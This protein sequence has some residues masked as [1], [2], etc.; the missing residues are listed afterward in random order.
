MFIMMKKSTKRILAGIGVV[1]VLALIIWGIKFQFSIPVITG[2]T[3][4]KY[5]PAQTVQKEPLIGVIG[6]NDL[7]GKY[8]A[9][10]NTNF[11]KALE[12][13]NIYKEMELLQETKEEK[14]ELDIDQQ[15]HR[16]TFETVMELIGKNT[17]AGV[18]RKDDL[19][20]DYII[21]TSFQDITGIREKLFDRLSDDE[22][23]VEVYRTRGIQQ[24]S[25]YGF[26]TIFEGNI[27]AASTLDL[28]KQSMDLKAGEA[29]IGNFNT[30]FDWVEDKMDRRADGFVFIND[31]N[32]LRYLESIY[33]KETGQEVLRN[34]L[35]TNT[36]KEYNFDKGLEI[37][38]Y[39]YRK[40]KNEPKK[41][42]ESN[43]IDLIPENPMFAGS[44][45]DFSI[46]R[47]LEDFKDMDLPGLSENVDLEMFDEY[48]GSELGYALL[49]PSEESF[50]Q[51]L[52]AGILLIESNKNSSLNHISD[53]LEDSLDIEL[54]KF[55]F[56]GI[57]YQRGG[58]PIFMGQELS[59]CVG[60]LEYKGKSIIAVTSSK[61][62][63]EKIIKLK[64]G[65][66]NSLKDSASWQEVA[67]YL[68][69][70]YYS[71]KYADINS[72]VEKIGGIAAR[73]ILRDPDLANFLDSEPLT[74][75]SPSGSIT[76]IDEKFITVHSYF[77]IKDLDVESWEEIF[78][79]AE[80][81][82][83]N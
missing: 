13:S 7:S 69:D 38:S 39:S 1:V 65:E 68:P 52:P 23:V 20:P 12:Q 24:F 46:E 78:D 64:R 15:D 2:E 4:L 54:E 9:L 26:Y 47:K 51:M 56:E 34:F 30:K 29:K 3:L 72:F 73:L 17:V 18:Y 40:E 59:I 83:N 28:V 76:N 82:V 63:L 60:A 70:R 25:E 14:Q 8:G 44:I 81:F 10:K 71:F 19:K 41:S 53:L 79:S 5:V 55:S 75:L 35:G 66:N 77:P 6:V 36:Y 37:K 50:A 32:G 67:G 80:S 16:I 62:S 74:W 58:I 22:D 48:I 43:T 33:P 45:N 49:G 27:I 21:V 42:R 61:N 57:E 31:N 11:F